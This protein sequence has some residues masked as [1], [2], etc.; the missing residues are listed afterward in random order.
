MNISLK[1]LKSLTAEEITFVFAMMSK[2]GG[3]KVEE[4]PV[5]NNNN[6]NN[7]NNNKNRKNNNRTKKPPRII[8][9]HDNCTSNELCL[10]DFDCPGWEKC[11]DE[12]FLQYRLIIKKC[13]KQ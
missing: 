8:K 3:L 1:R 5:H 13:E 10:Y 12:K 9:N 2:Y 7:H 6:H 11:D 4:Q